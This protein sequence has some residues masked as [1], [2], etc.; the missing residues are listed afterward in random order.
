MS[1]LYLNALPACPPSLLIGDIGLT[2]NNTITNLPL[3]FPEG[4]LLKEVVGSSTDLQQAVDNGYI[5]LTDFSGEIATPEQVLSTSLPVNLFFERSDLIVVDSTSGIVYQNQSFSVPRTDNYELCFYFILRLQRSDRPFWYRVYITDDIGNIT[6]VANPNSITGLMGQR[7]P[8][9][10]NSDYRKSRT[11]SRQVK[12]TEG[13]PYTFSIDVG[14][15][16]GASNPIEIHY[17]SIKVR[18]V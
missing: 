15:S 8:E 9:T 7:W 10:M 17:S 3:V 18:S 6:H 2:I 5:T 1:Q 4:P 14:K 13:V 16:T 11:G 12:L